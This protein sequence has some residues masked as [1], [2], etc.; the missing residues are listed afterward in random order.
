ML[1]MQK[2]NR[3][4]TKIL[5]IGNIANNA[6]LNAKILNESGKYNCDVLVPDYYH[7]M[8]SP[9]WED[10]KLTESVD[11]FFPNWKKCNLE[12][13]KR[14][15][16]FSNGPRIYAIK[17]L[18][19]KNIKDSFLAKIF[20]S[21]FSLLNSRSF[22]G[23]AFNIFL[24]IIT[25]IYYKFFSR[26]DPIKNKF[27]DE[28]CNTFFHDFIN[29][30]PHRIKE[31]NFFERLFFSYK[32]LGEIKDLCEK[33]DIVHAYGTD[34]IWPYVSNISNYISYEHATIRYLPFQKSILG[35]LVAVSY[36]KSKH[37]VI[38]NCDSNKYAKLLKVKNFSFVPHPINERWVNY[39][40]GKSL[41]NKLEKQLN[42][43]FIL[44]HPPRQH[45]ED[46]RKLQKVKNYRIDPAWYK[47]NDIFYE[48]FAKFVEKTKSNSSIVCV[49]WGASV[50]KSKS[51]QKKLKIYDRVLWIDPVSCFKMTD[52]VKSADILVDQ[53]WVGAFGST[54]PKAFQNGIPGMCNINEKDH[55]WC[56]DEMP[57]ALNAKTV[58]DVYSL[59]LK[60]Y[61]NRTWL[62]KIGLIGKDWYEKYH[63][64]KVIFKKLDNIYKNIK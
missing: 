12:G 35:R 29:L 2:K 13:F 48:G 10:A 14:P 5:H 6:Y 11:E 60:S 42:S 63:S 20:M 46:W 32:Q 3:K 38:T 22:F 53:F 7:I 45:W 28:M 59:L 43:D 51:L 9:E 55:K 34:P 8:G 39:K 41:R 61:N 23:K 57:P 54:L 24:K 47:G 15:E 58:E 19:N 64:N 26:H 62:K 52:Y 36:A 31:L 27:Y 21:I 44:F 30:F 49:N 17:Y 56:L 25:I 50:K 33:Y 37:V 4:K 1:Q 16:W 18:L 40:Y